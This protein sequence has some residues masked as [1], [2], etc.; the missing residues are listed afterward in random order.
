L[1]DYLDLHA[2]QR[3]RRRREREMSDEFH[4]RRSNGKK[5]EQTI[6]AKCQKSVAIMF[7]AKD[8]YCFSSLSHY[9][10]LNKAQTTQLELIPTPEEKQIFANFPGS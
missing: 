3:G 2:N 4:F 1:I 7:F 8:I 9:A 6:D 10:R 5:V